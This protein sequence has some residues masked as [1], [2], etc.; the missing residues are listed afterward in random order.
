LIRTQVVNVDPHAFRDIDPVDSSSLSLADVRVELL[1]PLCLTRPNEIGK[2]VSVRV[3]Q[4][5]DLLRACLRT[6]GSL[7]IV[8]E[9]AARIDFARLKALSQSIELASQG[10]SQFDQ[11]R[12]SGRSLQSYEVHGCLGWGEYRSVPRELLKWLEWGGRLQ[13]GTHRTAGAGAWQVFVL[14]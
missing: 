12:T 10:F 11:R 4:F 5:S 9:V 2:K 1:S 13:V 6:V 14:S 8:P 3:P 7:V